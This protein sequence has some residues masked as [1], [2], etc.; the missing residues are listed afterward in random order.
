MESVYVL[1][2]KNP[3]SDAI[4]SAMAYAALHNALGENNYVAA[5]IGHLNT[6]TSFLLEHFGFTPPLYIRSV[7]TQLSDI[8]YD[9]PPAIGAAVLKNAD[10][11]VNDDG[12]TSFV[13]NQNIFLAAFVA[14]ACIF[15]VLWPLFRALKK[16]KK[17]AE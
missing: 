3:D 4:V 7:R 11:V 14:A 1:G 10:T 5:R 13:P 17:D 8:D 16:E 6:E 15:L 9:K 12:T 2:H